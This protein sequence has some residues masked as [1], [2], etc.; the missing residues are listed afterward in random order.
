MLK[1]SEL[2]GLDTVEGKI[3]KLEHREIIQN[4]AYV[5]Q[6]EKKKLEEMNRAS[7]AFGIIQNGQMKYN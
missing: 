4:D 1:K 6:Q 2:D 3:S 5:L 7:L